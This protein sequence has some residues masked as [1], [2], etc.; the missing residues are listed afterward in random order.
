MRKW[1]L[2]M[3]V[4]GGHDLK[5][6]SMVRYTGAIFWLRVLFSWMDDAMAAP[7]KQFDASLI[8]NARYFA[9]VGLAGVG[10]VILHVA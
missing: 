7:R 2:P 5:T 8:R 3:F 4:L 6:R 9:V 1:L 10:S